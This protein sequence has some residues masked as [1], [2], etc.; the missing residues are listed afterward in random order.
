VKAAWWSGARRAALVMLLVVCAPAGAAGAGR[1]VIE[2]DGFRVEIGPVPDWV[3]RREV[4]ARWPWSLDTEG[5]AW[6]YWLVDNQVDRRGG[7]RERYF[8]YVYEPQSAEMLDEAAQHEISFEPSFQRLVLHQVSL[9]RDGRASDRLDPSRVTL[10]RREQQFE[11][12][13]IDGRASALLVFDDVRVGDRIQIAYTIE[14]GNPVMA[15]LDHERIALQWTDPVARRGFRVLF[16]AGTEP[17]FHVD[18]PFEAPRVVRGADAVEVVGDLRDLKPLVDEGGVPEWYPVF[19]ELVVTESRAWDAVVRWAL[20]LYAPHEA[21]AGELDALVARWR[22]LDGDAARALSAL[23]FVQ[24]DVRYFAVSMGDSSHRP[25]PPDVVLARR[26]GDCKDKTRLLVEIFRRLGIDA[27]PALVSFR[28]GRGIADDPPSAAVFDHVVVAAQIDGETWWLDPTASQQRGALG[29]IGGYPFGLALPVREGATALVPVEGRERGS[30]VN[31]VVETLRSGRTAS[32]TVVRVRI[33]WRGT[34]ADAVRRARQQAGA[35]RFADML[36]E[37]YARRYPGAER[38]AEVAVDEAA[39][40]NGVD[41][42][43]ALRVPEFWRSAG[44]G[45]LVGELAA[46]EVA[47]FTELPPV[48][49]GRRAPLSV[50]HPL[51]VEHVFDIEPPRG[52]TPSFAAGDLAVETAGVAYKRTIGGS[53]ERLELRHRLDSRADHVPVADL[54]EHFAG[55]SRINAGLTLQ[56]SLSGR[57]LSDGERERRLRRLLDGLDGG[58]GAP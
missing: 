26:Y 11:A 52:Y 25:N 3:A 13:Q 12:R 7:R 44:P 39:E 42:E 49:N 37:H 32:E 57:G 53:G 46:V 18:P 50:Q 1:Q 19:P 10:T 20:P 16:D 58:G 56:A 41:V 27:H 31:R 21:A 4:P 34:S 22:A 45:N 2:R 47:S 43:L 55:L 14:G 40:G 28:H 35:Q 38:T 33:E 54:R 15:G 51:V 6:R 5:T 30:A 48:T 17:R 36:V 24:D 29:D 23:R 8:E 9:V